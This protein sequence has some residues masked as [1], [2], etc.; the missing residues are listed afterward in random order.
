MHGA[1][2][3]K[4]SQR[5][6]MAR[7]LRQ[8]ILGRDQDILLWHRD[9]TQDASVRDRQF[10]VKQNTGTENNL[11]TKNYWKINKTITLTLTENN[12]SFW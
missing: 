11:S 7:D 5:D 1:R 12:Q 4:T 6:A 8:D 3:H 2:L 9:K 10:K